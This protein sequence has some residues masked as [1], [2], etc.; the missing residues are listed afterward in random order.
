MV[1]NLSG[2]RRFPFS[3]QPRLTHL[4]PHNLRPILDEYDLV[5]VDCPPNLGIITLNGLRISDAYI[6]PTIP[7]ILSTYG[8]PQIVK[9]VNAF[10]TELGKPIEPLGIVISKYRT[11][12]PLHRNISADLQNGSGR[13]LG[14]DVPAFSAIT[15]EN[16]QISMTA[17][18]V[19]NGRRTL[20]Q[21]YGYQGQVDVYRCLVDE[22]LKKLGA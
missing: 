4:L 15:P 6:I 5:L 13:R 3:P 9:R 8:I 20:R 19:P 17:E 2:V 11:Q 14:T 21:K 22:L 1:L 18:F 16:T 7:D 12:N 10:A